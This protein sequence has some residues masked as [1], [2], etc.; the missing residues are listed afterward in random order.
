MLRILFYLFVLR[1]KPRYR[2]LDT[3]VSKFWVKP[4]DCDANI[5]MNNVHYLKY[6]EHAR[7]DQLVKTPY[8]N[9][10]KRLGLKNI[11]ANTEISYIRSLLPF[12]RFEV[13]TR[14]TGWDEKYIYFEQLVTRHHKIYANAVIRMVLMDS[15]STVSPVKAFAQLMP[16]C[17]PPSLPQSAVKL[18]ELI[19]AQRAETGNSE[20]T[21][22]QDAKPHKKPAQAS[23]TELETL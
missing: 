20:C 6:L 14:I 15:R 13:R 2:I 1:V 9:G 19:A 18:N 5:H 16:G 7:L 3:V 22:P 8:L 10:L 4:W 17:P 21:S 11:I 23:P 12:Q